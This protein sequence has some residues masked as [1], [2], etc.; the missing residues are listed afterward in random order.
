MGRFELRVQCRVIPAPGPEAQRLLALVAL[1]NRGV[2]SGVVADTLWS[3]TS[4][5]HTYASLRSALGKL[6]AVAREATLVTGLRVWHR[7]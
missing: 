2:S 4:E 5:M 3:D 6:T 7:R 1:R